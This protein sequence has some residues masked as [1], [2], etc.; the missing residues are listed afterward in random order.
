MKKKAVKKAKRSKKA[1]SKRQGGRDENLS[2]YAYVEERGK[3]IAGEVAS[4]I[5]NATSEK[6][7]L[8]FVHGP[9]YSGK[10]IV[11]IYLSGC[12]DKEQKVVLAQPKVDRADVI[13]GFLYTR[14]SLKAK[15]ISFSSQKEI[16]DLF[17]NSDV[18]VVDEIG[19]MPYEL[20]SFFLKE[21][22]DFIEQ[23][24]WFVG[25]SLLYSSQRTEFLLPA[26]L[27]NR[28]LRAYRLTATCQKCGRRGADREQ[29][30]VDGKPAVASSPELEPPSE[31]IVYEAR[32]RD[33]HVLYS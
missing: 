30:L 20:Q 1:K 4:L 8:V 32:C 27:R 5:N 17:D 31:R 3:Q 2:I 6:G 23:G 16:E 29:R 13:D 24:G 11:G 21:V 28:A 33:C 18:V 14:K 10:T 25:L 9:V 22:D 26:M 7:G 15:A 19:F 12:L